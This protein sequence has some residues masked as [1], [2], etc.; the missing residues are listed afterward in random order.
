MKPTFD[1]VLVRAAERDKT[2]K[3]GIILPEDKLKENTKGQVISIGPLVK[4]VEVGDIVLWSKVDGDEI[5]S[6]DI[7][8]IVLKEEK[9]IAKLE[10]DE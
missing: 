8:Y 3:S 10:E 7:S 9:I 6:K 4:A 5:K 2:T 1:R